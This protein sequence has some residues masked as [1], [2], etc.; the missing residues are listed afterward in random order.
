VVGRHPYRIALAIAAVA[1]VAAVVSTPEGT[2]AVTDGL[3][4]TKL[5]PYYGC[6]VL[7]LSGHQ[8]NLPPG[9]IGGDRIAIHGT[10]GL[11]GSAASAG[12]LRATDRDV[13]SLFSLV[14]LGAPVFI[15][16]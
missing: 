2:F 4:G 1:A 13:V 11:V 3:A 15:H 9:W 10:P 16:S 8:P 6:C 14:P 12:C 5:G 7:A